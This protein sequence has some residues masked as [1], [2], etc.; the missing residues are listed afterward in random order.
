MD[1]FTKR[2]RMATAY[3]HTFTESEVGEAIAFVKETFCIDPSDRQFEAVL[4]SV[5]R[6]LS[7]NATRYGKF[8]FPD[9]SE[10]ADVDDRGRSSFKYWLDLFLDG[11]IEQLTSYV[12]RNAKMP[13]DLEFKIV[14]KTDAKCGSCKARPETGD[15]HAVVFGDWKPLGVFC[16][17]HGTIVG[18]RRYTHYCLAANCVANLPSALKDGRV[19]HDSVPPEACAA[20]ET[21]LAAPVGTPKPTD[22]FKKLRKRSRDDGDDEGSFEFSEE[23]KAKIAALIAAKA[24]KKAAPTQ[25]A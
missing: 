1:Y 15:V 22:R 18:Y 7:S 16:G 19:F 23:A 2:M 4:A 17:G 6:M 24:E 3:E 12:K 14:T 20:V 9:E 25:I 10:A 21:A 13:T 5:C 8:G 11:N